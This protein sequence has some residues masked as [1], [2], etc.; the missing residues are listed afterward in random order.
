MVKFFNG[1]TVYFAVGIADLNIHNLISDFNQTL[2]NA[3]LSTEFFVPLNHLHI[4][5]AK[6]N[7]KN[8]I[9]D[10]ITYEKI[11]LILLKTVN[12]FRLNLEKLRINNI[13]YG[14]E[15]HSVKLYLTPDSSSFIN[16][17]RCY[18]IETAKEYGILFEDKQSY[19]PHISILD[20][21]YG[22]LTNSECYLSE[23]VVQN[24]S[25]IFSNKSFKIKNIKILTPRSRLSLHVE[26]FKMIDLAQSLTVDF[27]LN[28]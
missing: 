2:I 25:K 21:M 12:K 18:V 15:S 11:S 22:S 7:L 27:V 17:L 28:R 10:F 24:F 4:S 26:D 13:F 14:H 3:G 19:V 20:E 6:F 23:R 8:N 5:L 9:K 16:N 1:K